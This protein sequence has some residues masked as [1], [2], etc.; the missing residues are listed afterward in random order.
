MAAGTISDE[1]ITRID[2][3]TLAPGSSARFR[4][5]LLSEYV[6]LASPLGL[7][8]ADISLAP[9]IDLSDRESD[10]FI[11]WRLADVDGFWRARAGMMRN[12]G[13]AKFW[14]STADLWTRRE[15]RYARSSSEPV[16]ATDRQQQPLPSASTH[17]IVLI[18]I[19]SEGPRSVVAPPFVDRS[20]FGEHLP[21]S[22]GESDASWELD[23]HRAVAMEDLTGL[24]GEVADI[25]VIEDVRGG[26]LRT[27]SLDHCVKR[28]LLLQVKEGIPDSVVAS[29]E[30]DLLAMPQYIGAIKNWRLSRVTTMRHSWTHAWEQ[31]YADLTGLQHDYMRSPFHWGV[32][33]SWFDPEGP[34]CIVEPGFQHLFYE[35]EKSVLSP[36]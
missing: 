14:E 23:A 30:A 33:D 31:E 8:L 20:W 5:R 28:T 4:D 3:L 34:R 26:A 12:P 13:L 29:F 18:N 15:R 10:M 17:S 2:E 22:V 16:P 9:P 1:P 25:A 24:S 19:S 35:V 6:P 32:V 21:G 11:T 27:P 7:E 36:A